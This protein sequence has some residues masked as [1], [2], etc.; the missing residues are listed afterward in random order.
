MCFHF[1]D[2]LTLVGVSNGVGLCVRGKFGRC[3]AALKQDLNLLAKK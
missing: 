2:E 1:L 3:N